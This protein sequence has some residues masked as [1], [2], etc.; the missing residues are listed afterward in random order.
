MASQGDDVPNNFDGG[1]MSMPYNDD[2]N[3]S[4]ERR[5]TVDSIP[6][7]QWTPELV[8]KH[9]HELH[10]VSIG[11]PDQDRKTISKALEN[12]MKGMQGGIYVKIYN[13]NKT[14]KMPDNWQNP[15]NLR[16][17]E[18]LQEEIEKNL[19]DAENAESI[20]VES[21]DED[22]EDD[23]RLMDILNEKEEN[24]GS[25]SVKGIASLLSDLLSFTYIS[26]LKM[27]N[28]FYGRNE[29]DYPFM[30]VPIVWK[31]V[32]NH[33]K[34]VHGDDEFEDLVA[35]N[36]NG[37]VEQFMN[38]VVPPNVH[39]GNGWRLYLLIYIVLRR[40]IKYKIGMVTENLKS[41][42][43]GYL[44]NEESFAYAYG[45][46]ISVKK[47]NTFSKNN[48]SSLTKSQKNA[49]MERIEKECHRN[50]AKFGR[51]ECK[52]L[53]YYKYVNNNTT[54]FPT[55]EKQKTLREIGEYPSK[56]PKGTRIQEVTK[57]S[58]GKY[59]DKDL[60]KQSANVDII[61]DKLWCGPKIMQI[62]HGKE[63][64]Y[65]ENNAVLLR[66]LDMALLNL[67]NRL[68]RTQ[69][70]FKIQHASGVLE[71][72][73]TNYKK[74][75]PLYD[76]KKYLQRWQYDDRPLIWTEIKKLFEG[77][78]VQKRKA[79]NAL[80]KI[81]KNTKGSNSGSST[82]KRKPK[83]RKKNPRMLKDLM[84]DLNLKF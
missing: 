1:L 30:R 83:N 20:D 68:K 23:E 43:N 59:K 12:T 40:F 26:V 16:E 52:K 63:Y 64:V 41:R 28:L 66:N 42:W 31:I 35:K 45:L 51:M 72:K 38:A 70:K 21:E 47:G 60:L 57:Q 78:K 32:M 13:F 37:T 82:V 49:V 34:N 54:I 46:E 65:A 67:F 2:D 7:P 75:S 33:L 10:R 9:Q 15:A 6:W 55:S 84:E 61:N 29:N 79:N 11:P 53:A 5:E 73:V 56:I 17:N 74:A 76:E 36:S 39:G 62:K 80:K 44:A 18:A 71:F 24:E 69:K 14:W 19:Q 50:F 4:K 22:Y 25:D 3:N 58:E 77:T 8:Q 27:A 48:Y 81:I